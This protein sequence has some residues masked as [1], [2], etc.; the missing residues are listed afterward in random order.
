MNY[1]IRQ[2]TF[3]LLFIV[4]IKYFSFFQFYSNISIKLIFK[5]LYQ[6]DIHGTKMK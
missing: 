3:Y 2:V 4:L 1:L 6:I 5:Y